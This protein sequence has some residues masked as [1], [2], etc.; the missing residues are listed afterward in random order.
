MEQRERWFVNQREMYKQKDQ[1]SWTYHHK[2]ESF[3]TR[4]H[5]LLRNPI[6]PEGD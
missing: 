6:N 2:F 1:T 5:I 3:N 4:E